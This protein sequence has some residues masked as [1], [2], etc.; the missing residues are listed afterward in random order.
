MSNVRPFSL[1]TRNTAIDVTRIAGC[2]CLVSVRSSSGP[3]KHRF[4][5][6]NPSTSSASSYVRWA[7]GYACASSLPMPTRWEPWPGN[8][9]AVFMAGRCRT[10]PTENEGDRVRTTRRSA[11]IARYAYLRCVT[12]V[13]VLTLV[14]CH[15]A[16]AP[17]S[18]RDVAP[19]PTVP[20]LANLQALLAR[21]PATRFDAAAIARGC[22]DDQSLGAYVAQLEQRGG[23]VRDGDIHHLR[24]GC[25]P[26]PAEP[27]P[28]ESAGGCRV[29]VL[30]AR[31]VHVRPRRRVAV[32]LRA[33][34]AR[35]QGRPRARPRDDGL[36]GRVAAPTGTARGRPRR[37]RGRRP[38]PGARRRDP[39]TRPDRG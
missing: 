30:H 22:P 26:F 34:P 3:S 16:P 29:L 5:S 24:G 23:P 38:C 12:R 27:M 8:R 39:T 25:G 31:R 4:E 32:A 36:P 20:D 19:A 15:A 13:L 33:A 10:A 1:S 14:A 2:V 28:I 7:V 6:E 17:L 11:C 37:A 21:A 9:S 35:A 18:N